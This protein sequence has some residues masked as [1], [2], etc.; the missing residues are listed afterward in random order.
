MLSLKTFNGDL[1][2]WTA[3]WDTFEFSIHNYPDLS[4]IDRFNYLTSLLKQSRE[5][6]AAAALFS[7]N[8]SPACSYCDQP[9]SSSSC[10]MMTNHR[11]RKQI[12]MKSGGCF[13]CLKNCRSSRGYYSCGKRY[14]SSLCGSSKPS[15]QDISQSSQ[16]INL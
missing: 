5:Y 8:S 7:N 6:P 10:Q 9:H 3:F 16:N 4:A 13:V 14:H 1:T 2:T 15:Q 11:R 12:L